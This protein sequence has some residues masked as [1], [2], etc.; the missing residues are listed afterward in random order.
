MKAEG[1]IKVIMN[2]KVVSRSASIRQA[3]VFRGHFC[4]SDRAPK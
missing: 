4:V 2:G 3:I 1:P